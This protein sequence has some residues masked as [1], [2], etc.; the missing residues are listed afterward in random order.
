MHPLP[1]PSVTAR[2]VE[3]AQASGTARAVADLARSF[4]SDV[5]D[6]RVVLDGRQIFAP[7]D[8]TLFNATI[9]DPSAAGPNAVD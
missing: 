5:Y 9:R 4:A 6:S 8:E 2:R 3:H 1:T 7:I